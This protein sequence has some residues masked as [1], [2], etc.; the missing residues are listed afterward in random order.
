MRS[1][2]RDVQRVVDT[3]T[4]EPSSKS[5]GVHTDC[6]PNDRKICPKA[7]VSFQYIFSFSFRDEAS[8]FEG[9]VSVDASATCLEPDEAK[10]ITPPTVK[11]FPLCR[12]NEWFCIAQSR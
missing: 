2:S 11:L 3:G 7:I 1:N 4:T 5:C 9:L 12:R 10:D 8:E 6:Q